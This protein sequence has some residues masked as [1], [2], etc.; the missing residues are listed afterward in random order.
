MDKALVEELQQQMIDRRAQLRDDI[1]NHLGNSDDEAL[2]E[3]HG[4]VHDSGEEAIAD[5]LADINIA[6]IE[7]ESREIAAIEAALLRIRRGTYGFCQ[8]CDAEIG[9][10]RLKANPSAERCIDC[11]SRAEDMRKDTTPSL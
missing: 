8:E 6:S 9:V 10:E 3:L 4:Q 2:R 1:L 5:T 7:Q 11:Q